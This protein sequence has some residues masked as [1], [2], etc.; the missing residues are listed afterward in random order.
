MNGLKVSLNVPFIYMSG[1]WHPTTGTRSSKLLIQIEFD[2]MTRIVGLVYE[3]GMRLA[4]LDHA[5][6]RDI[7]GSRTGRTASPCQ[8]GELM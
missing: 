6:V 5:P 4:N 8:D 3:T 7:K 1:S 2:K